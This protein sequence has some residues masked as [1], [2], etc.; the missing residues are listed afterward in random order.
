[1]H[2][3]Q[4]QICF[5][6]YPEAI[7]EYSFKYGKM[8]TLKEVHIVEI[9]KNVVEMIQAAFLRAITG[10]DSN[11]VYKPKNLPERTKET[12]KELT[13]LL[14][15]KV[16]LVICDGSLFTTLKHSHSHIP[17]TVC[18]YHDLQDR[19]VVIT[20][21]ASLKGGSRSASLYNQRCG[22]ICRRHYDQLKAIKKKCGEVQM[23][24]GDDSIKFGHVIFA[25]MPPQSKQSLNIHSSEHKTFL[26]YI[27]QCC[28][29]LLKKSESSSIKH[30]CLPVLIEGII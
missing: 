16:N 12:P 4:E 1:M 24:C 6:T 11:Q 30:L 25:I 2:V 29:N 28:I 13:W 27:S 14:P 20:E 8:S 15:N 18:R 7:R 23:K 10:P 26:G 9:D 21:Y 19:A 5:D 22:D 3:D 17:E